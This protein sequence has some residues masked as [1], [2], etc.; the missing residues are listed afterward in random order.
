MIHTGCVPNAALSGS[1]TRCQCERGVFV[2]GDFSVSG[3]CPSR[4]E[5]P[6]VDRQTHCEKITF[7]CGISIKM[8]YIERFTTPVTYLSQKDLKCTENRALQFDL[9][10]SLIFSHFDLELTL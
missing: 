10:I 9:Y 8:P 3:E 4:G 7:P 6:T 5:T 1:A 2:Q